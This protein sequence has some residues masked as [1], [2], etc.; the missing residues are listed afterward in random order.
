[1]V[2]LNIKRLLKESINKKELLP[3]THTTSNLGN[4]LNLVPQR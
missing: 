2:T 4:R 3:L 1:M